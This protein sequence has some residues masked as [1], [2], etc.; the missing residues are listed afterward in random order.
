MMSDE[1]NTSAENEDTIEQSDLE[2]FI[3]FFPSE[4]SRRSQQVDETNGNAS[5][6]VQTMYV[7]L[8]NQSQDRRGRLT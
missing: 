7:R 3:S 5:I 4:S 1:T 6:D 2:V 8:S